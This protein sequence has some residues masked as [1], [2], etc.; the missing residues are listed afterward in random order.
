MASTGSTIDPRETRQDGT[1]LVTGE[2]DGQPGGEGWVGE[3]PEGGGAS[4]VVA[5]RGRLLLGEPQQLLPDGL[6]Q[7]S[8]GVGGG[9]GGQRL[10]GRSQHWPHPCSVAQPQGVLVGG[11]RRGF[12]DTVPGCLGGEIDTVGW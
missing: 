8:G 10:R 9:V 11:R 4:A 2:V 5:G 1:G 6:D 7:G 3:W 12:P